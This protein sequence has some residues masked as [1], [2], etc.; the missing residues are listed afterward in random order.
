[1]IKGKEY[2]IVAKCREERKLRRK[3]L[4]EA[5]QAQGVR[6]WGAV[7]ALLLFQ[8]ALAGLLQALG[9]GEG[10]S[11]EGTGVYSMQGLCQPELSAPTREGKATV[12][13][14]LT[15]SQWCHSPGG[16]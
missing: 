2:K 16:D 15:N 13:S 11:C 8:R 1:M 14:N 10:C 6:G 12:P 7:R 3:R 9:R 4:G 5:V